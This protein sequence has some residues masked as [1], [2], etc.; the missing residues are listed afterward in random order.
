LAGL[1]VLDAW[2]PVEF[3]S[4][5]ADK[6]LD[7]YATVIWACWI[8]IEVLFK[9]RTLINFIRVGAVISRRLASLVAVLNQLSLQFALHF[10]QQTVSI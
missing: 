1:D 2:Y 9:P 10:S 8:L 4:F 5:K 7:G 6:I 3:A